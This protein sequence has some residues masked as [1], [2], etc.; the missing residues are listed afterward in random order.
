MK[1]KIAKQQKYKNYKYVVYGQ[2]DIF[3]LFFVNSVGETSS[4]PDTIPCSAEA[5]AFVGLSNKALP[6]Q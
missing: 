3:H 4:H 2:Q 5:P 1:I 6:C